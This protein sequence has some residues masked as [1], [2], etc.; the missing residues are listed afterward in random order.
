MN[1]EEYINE[2][3]QRLIE[4]DINLIYFIYQLVMKL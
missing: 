2:I 3:E 1:R 4:M